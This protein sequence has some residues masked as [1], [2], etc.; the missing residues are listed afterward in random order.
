LYYEKLNL[1]NSSILILDYHMGNLHS[2][3]R[4]IERFGIE[5]KISSDVEAI[6]K[7][8]KIILPG[9]GHF[10]EAMNNLTNLNLIDALNEAALIK[11]KP[12]LGICLGM[13]LMAKRSEEGFINGLGWFDA[14]ILKF[15]VKD[16]FKYKV[17]H[18]GWN[19]IHIKKDSVL[20]NGIPDLSEF[21]F[22]HSYFCKCNKENDILN[23]TDYEIKFTSAIEKD[24]I[25]GVQ[26]HPE[27]SHTVG[28]TL[29]KNFCKI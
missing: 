1:M 15:D 17:P 3:K 6:I 5:P 13:Q 11:K 20:M 28:E 2:I 8:D 10:S 19:Q 29:I 22:V 23:L 26:Y 14:E 12:I 4:K 27:K 21:Y 25:F 7:A 9:I 24:N 16:K 18:V